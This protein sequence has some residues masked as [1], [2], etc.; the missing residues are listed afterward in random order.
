MTAAVSVSSSVVVSLLLV[1]VHNSKYIAQVL[2]TPIAKYIDANIFR[3]SVSG[4][5]SLST[6]FGLII[7]SNI[8]ILPMEKYYQNVHRQTHV[9]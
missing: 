6:R 5:Y 1:V 4:P 7:S 2:A 3:P 9:K 8:V